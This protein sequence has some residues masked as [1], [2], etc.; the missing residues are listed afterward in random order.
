MTRT[1]RLLLAA[2]VAA[3]V[4]VPAGSAFAADRTG[5]LDA[6]TT[7]FAWDSKLGTGFTTLT[8]LHDKIPCGT[9]LVHDCDFTLLHVIGT[10]SVLL[11]TTSDQPNAVDTDLYAYLSD[12]DGTK[13]EGLGQS[14]ASTPTPNEAMSVDA[15]DPDNWFLVEIDY[16]DNVAGTVKGTATFTPTE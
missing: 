15:L 4:L 8:N 16:T 14:A 10:G 5:T 13:G 7:T 1:A 11:Q 2:V 9:P 12:A 3:G 6:T